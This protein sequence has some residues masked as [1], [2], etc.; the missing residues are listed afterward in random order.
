MVRDHLDLL[1]T[2]LERA[3]IPLAH[4]AARS[5]RPDAAADQPAPRVPGLLDERA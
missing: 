5:G 3:G 4:L 2:G 1:R